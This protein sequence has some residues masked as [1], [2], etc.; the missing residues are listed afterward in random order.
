MKAGT[1][2]STLGDLGEIRSICHLVVLILV[3]EAG[4]ADNSLASQVE[5]VEVIAD[6]LRKK[7][8]PEAFAFGED[9]QLDPDDMLRQYYSS[10][11][12]A[13]TMYRAIA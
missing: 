3:V 6:E 4:F 2:L 5:F 8:V 11:V 12:E 1:V 13:V 9:A 7:E 10:I